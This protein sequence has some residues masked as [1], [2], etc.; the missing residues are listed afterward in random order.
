M[1]DFKEEFLMPLWQQLLRDVLDHGEE[2]SPRGLRTKELLN[3]S[4]VVT[5]PTDL[6][7]DI[8]PRKAS[9]VMSIVELMYFLNGR[10][11]DVL[12]KVWLPG[13][14]KYLNPNTRRFDGGYGPSISAGLSYVFPML[15]KD[16][17][18]RRAWIPIMDMTHLVR[19][20]ETNDFPCNPGLAFNIR[21]NRLNM[22]VMTRSQ[23]LYYGYIYDQIEFHTLLNMMSKALFKK[24]GTVSH[25]MLSMH[26][27][28]K[29]FK[30]ADECAEYPINPRSSFAE[31][32][33][34]PFDTVSGFWRYVR[35]FNRL[36]D[37]PTESPVLE[38]CDDM[39]LAVHKY[40]TRRVQT[41]ARTGPFT[42]WLRD[43]MENKSASKAETAVAST[44]AKASEGMKFTHVGPNP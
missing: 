40:S 22:T 5:N 34:F 25:Y 18:T 6:V 8:K 43:W 16:P 41:P 38:I 35:M 1:S 11:D 17:D 15:Q 37:L 3:V 9:P 32:F 28:E 42:N 44:E 12:A 33:G 2:S 31:R 13:M 21:D 26:L 30:G 39:A 23:D 4:T 19:M 20:I 27:Y 36:I 14:E 7:F 10:D 24:V 29:D